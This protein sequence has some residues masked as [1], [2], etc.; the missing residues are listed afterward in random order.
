V[1]LTMKETL[2][3]HKARAQKGVHCLSVCISTDRCGLVYMVE[4][5]QLSYSSA[6]S[7]MARAS[8]TMNG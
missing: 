6:C 2:S 1:G 8:V 3:M 5:G 4:D 7:T